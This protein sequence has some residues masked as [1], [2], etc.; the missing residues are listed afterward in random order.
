MLVTRWNIS[1]NEVLRDASSKAYKKIPALQFHRKNLVT[2][3]CTYMFLSN[4][5]PFT[6]IKS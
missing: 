3:E 4:N 5:S 2:Q 1:L 6:L